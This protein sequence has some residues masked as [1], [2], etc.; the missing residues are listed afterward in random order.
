M[1]LS[2]LTVLLLAIDP[3]AT[4]DSAN[5]VAELRELDQQFINKLQ[6][7]ERNHIAS[8]TELASK[9]EGPGRALAYQRALSLA[10]TRDLYSAAEPAAEQVIESKLGGAELQVL[11]RMVNVVAEADSGDYE[12]SLKTLTAYLKES[13]VDVENPVLP[14]ESVRAISEAYYLRLIQAREYEIARKVAELICENGVVPDVV[15]TFENRLNLFDLLGE[16]AP[17]LEGTNVDGDPISLNDYDG[18]VVL[19][20]FWATWCPPCLTEIPRLNG[21]QTLLENEDFSILGV[22]VDALTGTGDVDTVNRIVRRF[23]IDNN[24]NWPSI[25]DDGNGQTSPVTNFK[26]TEIPT[27]FLIGR[28]GSIIAFDLSENRGLDV[29]QA[30]LDE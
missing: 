12:G 11:A 25:V 1:P 23:V 9:L 2:L 20:Y 19:V 21:L 16:S 7:L 18:Q 24:V 30:A 28:D 5:E 13:S 29:I 26:V 6:E 22:N 15:E 14:A 4:Q 3:L 27:N 8:L 10:V 17:P